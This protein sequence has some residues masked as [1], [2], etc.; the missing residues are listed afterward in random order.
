M[1]DLDSNLRL[2]T[3]GI[4]DIFPCAALD[5]YLSH[6]RLSMAFEVLSIIIH[7]IIAVAALFASM[8][9]RGN[10]IDP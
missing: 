9:I 10:T 3:S 8:A 6:S 4:G 1:Q 2:K 7:V 5:F